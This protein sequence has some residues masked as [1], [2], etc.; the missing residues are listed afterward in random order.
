MFGALMPDDRLLAFQIIVHDGD[1]RRRAGVVAKPRPRNFNRAMDTL[2][3]VHAV[4]IV[5]RAGIG[6]TE[7]AVK[8]FVVVIPADIAA[9]RNLRCHQRDIGIQRGRPDCLET[10]LTSPLRMQVFAIPGF[11]RLQLLQRAHKAQSHSIE[12][13]DFGILIDLLVEGIFFTILLD[14]GIE[15]D[16]V[17][18]VALVFH[19]MRVQTESN[20]VRSP[21]ANDLIRIVFG[22]P[23]S[24]QCNENR[25]FL[26]LLCSKRNC[27]DSCCRTRP[28]A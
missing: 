26:A 3:H 18:L 5:Q 28:C 7:R 22:R 24:V 17:F 8:A 20:F 27:Q 13:G 15:C 14:H 21:S 4:V 10:A 12:I 1:A 6:W 23:I 16:V 9:P 19:A 2:R 11:E 25:I